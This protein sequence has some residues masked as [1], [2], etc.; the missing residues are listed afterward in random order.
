MATRC[1][2]PHCR[3]IFKIDH[4]EEMVG[5]KIRCGYCNGKILIQ[6]P[7]VKKAAPVKSVPIQAAPLK[8]KKEPESEIIELDE[9]AIVV[10][11]D[12]NGDD[13][14]IPDVEYGADD[15]AEAELVEAPAQDHRLRAA[16][17]PKKKKSDAI[18]EVAGKERAPKR[19]QVKS[20]A[21]F[22]WLAAGAVVLCTLCVVIVILA[23][24]AGSGGGAKFAGPGEY[25]DFSPA[26]LQLSAEVP[27]GWEQKYGGG[28]GGR[29]IFATFTSGKISIDIR[30]SIGGGAMGA[31]QLA[32]HQQAGADPA[33]AV[34]SIH[35]AHRARIAEDFGSYKEDAESRTVKTRG[36][37]PGKVSDFDADQGFL[38][39]GRVRG[40]RAT[41]MNQLHQFNVVC[42]CPA[43]MFDQVQ[44]IFEKVIES[45]GG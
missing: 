12:S 45:L 44:P 3:T 26:N 20:S 13:F 11:E 21:I 1:I 42:K 33:E 17:K 29:P 35:E 41:V 10:D 14:Q 6:A 40:C 25:V 23:S 15:Y 34:E 4:I 7:P 39:G 16:S 31:A 28:E 8:K 19:T 24:A 30:E 36:F 9:D 2:C 22:L 32:M 38:G 43:A 27:K 18:Q 5:T 37:G